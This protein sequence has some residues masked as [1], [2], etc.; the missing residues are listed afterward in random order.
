M[1]QLNRGNLLYS[2]ASLG[3]YIEDA[4]TENLFN[5]GFRIAAGIL[6]VLLRTLLVLF[7]LL[8]LFLSVYWLGDMAYHARYIEPSEPLLFGLWIYGIGFV[9]YLLYAI[10][11]SIMCPGP[12]KTYKIWRKV[13]RTFFRIKTSKTF[14]ISFINRSDE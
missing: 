8:P 14:A 3:G 12:T 1:I 9:I 2:L 7:A 13:S 5:F 10:S 6:V 11:Q 4:R